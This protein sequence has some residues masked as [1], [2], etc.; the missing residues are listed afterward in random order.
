MT[1]ANIANKVTYTGNGSTSS[2]DF[3][4]PIKRKQD[5]KVF[6][7]L[8]TSTAL[9]LLTQDTDYTVTKAITIGGTVLLSSAL[10]L[11]D[12][13]VI[14]RS[15]DLTQG[16]DITNNGPYYQESIESALDSAIM[17]IQDK[18]EELSR[19]LKI[20]ISAESVFSR[21]I[22]AALTFSLFIILRVSIKNSV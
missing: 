18:N 13:I 15:V 20:P 6:K 3:V 10:P 8:S 12:K 21:F 14:I 22:P 4:F 16:A 1:I 7:K 11:N 19:C 5:V 9:T 17:M 2:Y